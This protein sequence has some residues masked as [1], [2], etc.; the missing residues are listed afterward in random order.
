[1]EMTS[2]WNNIR[3]NEGRFHNDFLELCQFGK[4]GETGLNRPALSEAHS[5]AREWFHQKA[6]QAG[7]QINV[8]GAGNH[9]AQLTCDIPGAPTLLIGSHLDSVPT[10]GRFDGSLG[11]LAALETL[12]TIK[13]HEIH[14]PVCLEAIDFT[15]EEGT[16]VSFLGSYAYSGKLVEENLTNPRSDPQKLSISLAKAG[17]TAQGILNARHDPATLVGYLEMHVEQG[18]LLESQGVHIGV[19]THISGIAFYR[20]TY[21]GK[22]GHAGTISMSER[23][24]AAQGASAFTL[25]ARQIIL[26]QFP[27]CFSNVGVIHFEP[28]LF[29]VIPEKA[30]LGFE[31]RSAYAESFKQLEMALLQRAQEEA[32]RYNLYL[33]VEFLGQRDPVELNSTFRL[34]IKDAATQIGLSTMPIISR[35]G[36]DAQA[37]ADICPTGMI[38][39]P[40]VAGISHSPEE[41]SHWEDCVNGANVLLQTTLCIA[42]RQ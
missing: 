4:I 20:L 12:R 42:N 32:D 34:T 7:L 41:L 16:L 23:Q 38:F 22:A 2:T 19:V 35:A 36:H 30:V 17:L 10:G 11:V 5:Q 31:F 33:D 29:N 9:S 6:R 25:A 27:D 28:G 8:D 39:I 40:S 21:H 3:I 18:P 1:M 13:E 14:L 37:L 24:D 15:D 26:D